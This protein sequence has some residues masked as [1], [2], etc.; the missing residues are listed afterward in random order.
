MTNPATRLITLILLLQRQ[1]GQQ[2]AELAGKLGVSVRTL[3]RYI[4][5]LDELGIPVYSERGPHGGFSLVRGYKMP[6]L[7]FTPDEAV[8]VYLG[9]SLV[10]EVWGQLYKGASE[11]ALA[12]LDNV[13]PDEQ[14]NEIAWARRSLIA[15]GM[16]RSDP[17]LMAPI[18]EKLRQAVREQRQ[19][20]MF[21]QGANN[22]HPQRRRV[23]PYALAC[24]GGWWYLIGHCNFRQ[25]M[26][27]FRLD[28]IQ[29]MTL[30]SQSFQMAEDF[31]VNEY[32]AREF[33]DQPQIRA[34]MRFVPEAAHIVRS[35][36]AMW[37]SLQ[38]LEDGSIEVTS[39]AP[40]L[41]WLASIALSY[42][43]WVTVIEP[44][45]LRKMVREWA[46]AIVEQYLNAGE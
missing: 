2:A 9:T 23:D 38:E 16:Q 4:E 41:Y 17:T 34:R 15:T 14:R 8:A 22:P 3:H 18:L 13:L 31:D 42:A 27:T 32:L 25:A 39:L 43:T 45:E 37:E 6:P 1:P 24:Q 10:S 30:L 12:K 20:E 46:Q 28:R 40:D 29:E 5:M 44:E 26:R 21:Y 19:I 36:R 11:A 35:N 7:V 33:R